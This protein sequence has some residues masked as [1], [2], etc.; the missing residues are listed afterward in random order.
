VTTL[1]AFHTDPAVKAKYVARVRMHRAADN[2]KQG[3][4]WEMGKGCAIGCTLEA[5]EH[6]R[7][8]E[9]LGLPVWLA[10]LEDAIFEGLKNGEAQAWPEAFLEAITPG[11]D[12]EPVRHKLAVRRIERLIALQTKALEAKHGYGVH[13]AIEKTIAALHVVRRYHEYELGLCEIVTSYSARSAAR[14]AAYSAR[15][16]AYSAA[17]S[18]RSAYSAADAAADAAYSAR[19]AADAAYSADSARSAA[20]SAAYSARSAAYSARSARSAA[21]SAAD[22]AAD[23]AYSARS[24]ADAAYS[25]DSARSAA[26]SAADAAYS[27]AWQQEA[28]DLLESLRECT[29]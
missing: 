22:A 3:V 1:Q 21:Y 18:A 19:S 8:P 4:G 26:R 15:S 28:K 29:P 14:S 25:A 9:E 11:A 12:V 13:E 6:E 16:A 24:A 10:R 20:R 17:Y 23:A 7:Y 5:Y 2:L 27:A